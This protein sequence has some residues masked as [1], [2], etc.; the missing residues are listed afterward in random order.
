MKAL[1]VLL[2]YL[3]CLNYAEQWTNYSHPHHRH[4]NEFK[5]REL[6]KIGSRY[7]DHQRW[8]RGR[9]MAFNDWNPNFPC[10]RGV[11]PIGEDTHESAKDGYNYIYY[12]I[13]ILQ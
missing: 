8:E 11:I 10:V 4:Y 5:L 9:V 1:Y 13:F 7:Y 2:A 3:I 12:I 6:E